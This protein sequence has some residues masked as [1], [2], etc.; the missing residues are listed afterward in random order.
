MMALGDS[1]LREKIAGVAC[2]AT[3]FIVA[4][5]R[6]VGRDFWPIIRLNIYIA[7]VWALSASVG[8]IKMGKSG[9]IA[10]IAYA[11]L[12]FVFFFLLDKLM[13]VNSMNLQ[14][15]LSVG[16]LE[17]N[18][19]LIIRSPGDEASGVLAVFQFLS[20]A[21]V[22]LYLF[23]QSLYVN[24]ENLAKQPRKLFW[25]GVAALPVYFFPFW[26][27]YLFGKKIDVRGLPLGVQIAV[28]V[29]LFISATVLFGAIFTLVLK[30]IYEIFAQEISQREDD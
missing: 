29:P 23:G 9:W 5:P 7:L 16:L 6:D 11:L 19:L 24:A 14:E 27:E 28:L 2:L 15:E 4:R 3:P 13:R 26:F 10:L 30:S 18:D 21:T 20:Q 8:A 1:N 25:M 22:R 17:K 12:V